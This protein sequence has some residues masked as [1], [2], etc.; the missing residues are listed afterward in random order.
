MGKTYKIIVCGKKASGK[1]T[2]LEQLIYNNANSISSSPNRIISSSNTAMNNTGVV[3]GG[4]RYFSTIED[5]YVA[6]WEKDKGIKEKLRFYDTRG[7]DNS[8]DTECINQMRHLFQMVDGAVLVFSSNDLDSVK[9]VEKLKIEIEKSKDKKEICHFIL[10]DNQSMIPLNLNESRDQLTANTGLLASSTISSNASNTPIFAAPTTPNAMT[11]QAPATLTTSPS[12]PPH[13]QQQ[14]PNSITTPSSTTLSPSTSPHK[15]AIK[16][17][18]QTRLRVNV[19]EVNN[20]EKRE[21][22]CKPFI[23]L[24]MNMTQINTKGSMNL[25]IKKPKVF[26]S[27]K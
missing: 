21:L 24:A 26:S 17:D 3:V 1:T 16:I 12:S 7:M 20:I 9:C 10:I 2:L 11:N 4:E 13:S 14:N 27:N 22:L 6:C 19:Y 18:L 8:N 25:V 5:I 23:D 15:E